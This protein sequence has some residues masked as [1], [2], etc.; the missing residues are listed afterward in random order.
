VKPRLLGWLLFV[1]FLTVIAYASQLSSGP[2]PEDVAYRWSSSIAGVIQYAIVFGIV[3]LITRHLD[4]REFLAFRRPRISWWRIA[5]ISALILLAV[6]VVSAIVSPF[7]NPEREQGLIPE[8][9]EPSKIAPFA[10]Y[11][12]VVVLVAPFVEELMF[13]GAGYGLL[14]PYGYWFAI[15]GVGIAFALVHGLIAG[16][17]I[18]ATFG[19]GLA[20]LRARSGSIYPGMLLHAA[21][22]AFGL[23]IGIATGG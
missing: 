11:A 10:A 20:Y 8:R 22:N 2:P 13:R 18:I 4:R 17:V 21:F 14:E 3:M 23:A 15:I 9:W 19:I 1:A 5:G 6:F 7:S 12:A 16:F